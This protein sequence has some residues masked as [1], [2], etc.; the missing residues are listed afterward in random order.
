MKMFRK[1]RKNLRFAQLKGESTGVET[2]I[3]NISNYLVNT[4]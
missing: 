4:V 3:D 1:W 2:E